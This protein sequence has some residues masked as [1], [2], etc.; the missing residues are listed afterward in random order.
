MGFLQEAEGGYGVGQVVRGNESAAKKHLAGV[1]YDDLV[2]KCGA[3][4]SKNF[5]TLLGGFPTGQHFSND[6]SL[7]KLDAADKVVQQLDLIQCFIKELNIPA[8]D[9]SSKDAGSLTVRFQPTAIRR[10]TPPNPAPALP[11]ATIKKWV[12]SN[13]RVSIDGLDAACARVNKIDSVSVKIKIMTGAS[14]VR[15]QN[16]IFSTPEFSNLALTLPE[17]HADP[18]YQWYEDFVLKGNN[19]EAKEKNGKIEL[20]SPNMTEV[21]FTLNFNHLGIFRYAPE[22]IE[23]NTDAIRRVR[24]EMYC[25][26]MTFAASPAVSP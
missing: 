19:G 24:V 3:G 17:T 15:N 14:E 20:L 26:S 25:Q 1:A 7:L 23:K 6:L 8:L 10:G 2:V 13:F 5:Y 11:P 18:F 4:M 16:N 12:S 22:I 21:L 9:A